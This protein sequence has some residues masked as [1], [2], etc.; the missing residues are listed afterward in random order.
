M[1]IGVVKLEMQIF[2]NITWSHHRWV[3]WLNGYGQLDLSHTLLLL[4]VTVLAKVEIKFFDI[5]RSHD[6]RITWLNGLDTITLNRKG[7]S[8]SNRTLQQKCLQACVTNWGS[9]VLLQIRAN[10]V[11]NWGSFIITNWGKCCYKLGQ[12]LQIRATF[13]TK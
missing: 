8:K 9:F 3:T 4:V 13:I 5:M 11:T 7:F 6:Q 10:V 2:A 1:V 12:L